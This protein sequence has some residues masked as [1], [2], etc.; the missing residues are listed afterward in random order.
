[1]SSFLLQWLIL[2]CAS[3][4]EAESVRSISEGLLFLQVDDSISMPTARRP[5]ISLTLHDS[6]QGTGPMPLDSGIGPVSARV[7]YSES[8]WDA[9]IVIAGMGCSKYISS[10]AACGLWYTSS[11]YVWLGLG[12]MGIRIW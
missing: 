2:S 4:C 11:V 9:V 8:D 12:L 6:G 1:M 10:R 7:G 3:L 5:H